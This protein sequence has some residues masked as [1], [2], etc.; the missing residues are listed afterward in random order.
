MQD[1]ALDVGHRQGAHLRGQ[2][3][4]ARIGIPLPQ[5]QAGRARTAAT[6]HRANANPRLTDDDRQMDDALLGE[7]AGQQRLHHMRIHRHHDIGPSAQRRP[8]PQGGEARRQKRFQ[9]AV[10]GSSRGQDRAHP[11]LRQP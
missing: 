4:P 6:Q 5:F 2:R 11:G 7:P 10:L 9:T 3:R 8:R 1:Q